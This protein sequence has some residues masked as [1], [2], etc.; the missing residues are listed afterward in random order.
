MAEAPKTPAG[1]QRLLTSQRPWNYHRIGY[2]ELRCF[3]PSHLDLEGTSPSMESYS[4][5]TNDGL[6]P[7]GMI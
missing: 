4:C 2:S 6:S 1:S 7:N 5:D 3:H